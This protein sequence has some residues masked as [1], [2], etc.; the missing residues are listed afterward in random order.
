M[1]NEDSDQCAHAHADLS[2][3]WGHLS[4]GTLSH[5]AAHLTVILL[6]QDEAIDVVWSL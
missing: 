1:W 6:L 4:E 2:L 5:I 3:R